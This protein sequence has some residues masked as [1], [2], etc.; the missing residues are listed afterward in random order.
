MSRISD[1]FLIT[2]LSFAVFGQ[3][4][5]CVRKAENVQTWG[6][7]GRPFYLE[8]AFDLDFKVTSINLGA[9]PIGGVSYSSLEKGCVAG[10]YLN[11][12]VELGSYHSVGRPDGY[13]KVEG[14]IVVRGDG[15]VS[16]LSLGVSFN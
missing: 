2:F 4:Q 10:P 13:S 5:T 15:G 11:G 16:F 9:T 8:P 14:H 12:T 7:E 3:S 6:Q 1:F